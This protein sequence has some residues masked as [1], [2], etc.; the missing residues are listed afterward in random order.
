MSCAWE[1]SSESPFLNRSSIQQRAGINDACYEAIPLQLLPSLRPDPIG[2]WKQK[3]GKLHLQFSALN[4]GSYQ[5][6]SS[7]D[8]IHWI[9][10][11]TLRAEHGCIEMEMLPDPAQPC[12]FYRAA[13][14]G[15]QVG[16]DATSNPQATGVDPPG[17]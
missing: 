12:R 17:S 8:M 3:D 16:A 7:P 11:R 13:L 10:V 14:V 4:T 9:P 2:Q 6:Q 15:E 1:C 5:I